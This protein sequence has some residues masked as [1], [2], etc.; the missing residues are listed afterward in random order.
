MKEGPCIKTR[1]H[2]WTILAQ[3]RSN[4][5]WI[6]LSGCTHLIRYRPFAT[7]ITEAYLCFISLAHPHSPQVKKP[8]VLY[9]Q[10]TGH[11]TVITRN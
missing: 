4:A 6:F 2:S 9:R 5:L 7:V 1:T 11:E 8:L 10:R 3:N